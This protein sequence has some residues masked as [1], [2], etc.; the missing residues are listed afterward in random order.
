MDSHFKGSRKSSARWLLILCG[1]IW[2]IT[3]QLWEHGNKIE[4]GV[5][6]NNHLA[7]DRHTELNA[8]IDTIFDRV[9]ALRYLPLTSRHFFT[10]TKA[11]RKRRKL[12]DKQKWIRDTDV[13]LK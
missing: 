10:Q 7:E 1:R 5:D 8:Q 13:V 9:P 2:G 12:Q 4:H 6:E 11:W 3:K